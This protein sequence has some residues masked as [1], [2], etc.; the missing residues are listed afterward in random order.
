MTVRQFKQLRVE[1][2]LSQAELA[3][4]LGVSRAAVSR[5]EAGKRGIDN[6]LALAMDC[7]AERGAKKGRVKH[8]K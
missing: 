3:R 5:W 4:V 6:V 8:G 2:K 7:L 1:M